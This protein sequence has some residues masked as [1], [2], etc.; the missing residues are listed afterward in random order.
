M[1]PSPPAEQTVDK[2]APLRR[3][4]SLPAETI[5]PTS[6]PPTPISVIRR[7]RRLR[8]PDDDAMDHRDNDEGT[9]EIEELSP[10]AIIPD[11]LLIMRDPEIETPR[12]DDEEEETDVTSTNAAERMSYATDSYDEDEEGEDD[13][14]MPLDEKEGYANTVAKP[15]PKPLR[16]RKNS[17]GGDGPVPR[18]RTLKP[19]MSSPG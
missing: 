17:D 2:P 10:E 11:S 12:E 5:R 8:I 6:R 13:D 19:W 15:K 16:K 18:K 3:A 9:V 1:P 7:L 14:A 4:S